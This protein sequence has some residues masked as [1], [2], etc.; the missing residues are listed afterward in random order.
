MRLG[1]NILGM[2]EVYTS[3]NADIVNRSAQAR[4]LGIDHVSLCRYEKQYG[5]ERALKIMLKKKKLRQIMKKS[6]NLM[7]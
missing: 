2:G 1:I 5:F 4:K 7:G 6:F 3:T